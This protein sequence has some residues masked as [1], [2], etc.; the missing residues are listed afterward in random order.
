MRKILLRNGKNLLHL[1]Q[2]IERSMF[3]PT[4]YKKVCRLISIYLQQLYN[5][6]GKLLWEEIEI[7]E[8]NSVI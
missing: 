6:K 3:S 1:K 5:F 7:I 8:G 4:K 2:V